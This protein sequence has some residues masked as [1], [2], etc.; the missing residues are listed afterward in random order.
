MPNYLTYVG[1]SAKPKYA[2]FLCACGKYVEKREDQVRSGRFKSCGC[3][4][5]RPMNT[6]KKDDPL[7]NVFFAHK[8]N[9]LWDSY[10]DFRLEL[11]TPDPLI[12]KPWVV[13]IIAGTKIGPGNVR[14]GMPE[15]R[16]FDYSPEDLDLYH[17][18]FLEDSNIHE[19]EKEIYALDVDDAS[20]W[21]RT[22]N[23]VRAK[24]RAMKSNDTEAWQKKVEE[25]SREFATSERHRQ[26]SVAF[27]KGR[28]SQTQV[29]RY[30]RFQLVNCLAELLEKNYS[31]AEA[32]GSGSNMKA[33]RAV[34]KKGGLD[35]T[36]LAHI[37]VTVVMD[38]LAR[39]KELKFS[40]SIAK[41]LLEIGEKIDHQAFINQI[42][43]YCPQE[44]EKVN[45][46]YLKNGEMGYI[47]K[48][49]NAK[50]IVSVALPYA[51]MSTQ[52]KAHVG[53]WCF[54]AFESLT[55]WFEKESVL[56]EDGKHGYTNY[57]KL[58]EDGIKH[59]LMLQAT[60]D[61]NDYESW[62]MV[63]PPLD[64]DFVVDD[65]GQAATQR[66][67]YLLEHPGS[68]RKL[69]HNDHGTQPSRSAID[70]INKCQSIG[71]KV[72]EFIY[73]VQVALLT[74]YHE[75]GAFK[76]YEADSWVDEHWP[77]IDP[78]VWELPARHKDYVA[79]KRKLKRA[80]GDQKKAEKLHK[81]PFRVLMAASRFI[82]ADRFY[83]SCYFDARL[84]I[85]THSVGLTYQGSDYQ[86][87][88]LKFADGYEVTD[89]NRS[90]VMNEMLVSIANT[91][92]NDKISYADRIE[93]AKTLV[94]D[95]EYVARDPL[96]TQSMTSWTEADEPFQFLAL[97]REYYEVFEWRTKTHTDIPGGRDA[98]NSGNQI[99]GAMC[100]DEKTC[101]YT[102]VITEWK[103]N[104]ATTPQDLYGVV[105][106]GMDVY[107]KSDVWVNGELERYRKQALKR[108]EKENRSI[109]ENLMF[110]LDKELP[111]LL[112]RKHVKRAVMIDA[113]GG[114]WRSKNAHISEE[115]S[116]TA[117]AKDIKISLA[118][119][120]LVTSACILS[121]KSEFPLSDELN[122]WFK[123]VGKIAYE[124]GLTYIKWTTPDGSHV[125]Q[126]YLHPNII[127]IE[128]HAMG[129]GT[130]QMPKRPA[131]KGAKVEDR[132]DNPMED[133][134]KKKGK[135]KEK[136]IDN[137]L[138]IN[139]RSGWK[140][141]PM[142]GKMATALGANFTH[143]H[144]ASI[145]RGAMNDI[146]TPFFGI[147]DCLYGPHGTL[148]DACRKLRVSFLHVVTDDA[149]QGLVDS[150]K[151]EMETRPPRGNADISVCL[152]SPYMFS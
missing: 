9:K 74:K 54:K 35:F 13:P 10:E 101:Y 121:Q 99:L 34:I 11:G 89:E 51:F 32:A 4:T 114:S 41:I 67:G 22:L 132:P 37:T 113:Y 146:D 144:D 73:N 139:I 38:K 111:K 55:L 2:I 149:L 98:T 108:A 152:D 59:R 49:R 19:C 137:R 23:E 31:R 94:R 18:K 110:S 118:E 142:S 53:G 82:D 50:K 16:F 106:K 44:F 102:N 20:S 87:S 8:F 123:T 148:E 105:A 25:S 81:N 17:K 86:K 117:K 126:E 122:Q 136:K 133:K 140:D 130:Y 48:I 91:Y 104:V 46:W 80:Y 135:Q 143:S 125:I 1:P 6:G 30:F 28:A 115:L 5:T 69:I 29:A 119:K 97:L 116:E 93:F 24:H 151:L 128:T 138:C 14:F 72:N 90:Q 95:L 124:N 42:Q 65:E 56:N 75:I 66:G 58:S 27:E 15:E 127:Q 88:L 83:F 134:K 100:R 107:L 64:W 79:A 21:R 84:R 77:R 47:Q 78:A 96:T 145:I 40:A 36:T 12:K 129:G 70:A 150:N 63:H 92:G 52:D 141:E 85:Y 61:L 131:Q 33:V 26:E 71:F 109:D 3:A 39:N 43:V 120:R 76:T 103:D 57:L 7:Y 60:A 147:H 112:N 45:R 68:I 62:P